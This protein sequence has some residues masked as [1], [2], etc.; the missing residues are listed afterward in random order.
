MTPHRHPDGPRGRDLVAAMPFAERLGV[1]I[2]QA[3]PERVTGT[4]AWAP[5]LCTVGGALHGGALLSLADSVGAVCAF[6]H[7]P[8]G[9]G[10]AT[11]ETKTNLF[12]A[13]RSGTVRATA[14]PLHVGRTLIVVQTDLTDDR[15]RLLAQT[16]Q[17]QAVLPPAP[18][19]G[20]P[21]P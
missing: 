21:T 7:L 16:T 11:I 6:L 14:R 17:T 19:G 10:T 13:V 15:E 1:E 2:D 5:E 4:L 3:E 20:A 9:A 12:R 8:P 18:D